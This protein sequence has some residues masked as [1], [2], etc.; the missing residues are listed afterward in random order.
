MLINSIFEVVI[1]NGKGIVLKIAFYG[2]GGIGKSTIATNVSALLGKKGKN[3]LHIG[4]DPKADS[5]RLLTDNKIPTV[6]NQVD[7]LDIVRTSDVVFEGKYGVQCVEAGGPEA[8]T[9]CAGL[10]IMTAIDELNRLEVFEQSRDVIVY[11]VL[12]DVVCGGF[13]VPMRQHFVDKVYVVTS[14]DYMS[15]YAANNILKGVKRYGKNGQGFCGGIIG[16]HIRGEFDKAVLQDFCNKVKVPCITFLEDDF[17]I[18]RADFKRSLFALEQDKSMNGKR[19]EEF[20]ENILT[21]K[22]T[23]TPEPMDNDAMEEFAS[24]LMEK[25]YEKQD[26]N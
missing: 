26:N 10:G 23:Y 8:G 7:K 13:S 24:T 19:L 14:V 25:F 2:K 5:T 21:S 12:G 4:C 18:Q 20:V 15:L 9:G 22:T 17:Q 6:L 3:V 11:D 1:V 16:N